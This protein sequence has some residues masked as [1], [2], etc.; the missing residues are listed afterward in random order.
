MSSA[1][2]SLLDLSSF[3]D[4]ILSEQ[5]RHWWVMLTCMG[6]WTSEREGLDIQESMKIFL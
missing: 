1:H 3:S 2:M 4:M 5:W 6:S